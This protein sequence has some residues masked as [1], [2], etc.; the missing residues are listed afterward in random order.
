MKIVVL[1]I[2]FLLNCLGL[3]ASI[4]IVAIT[5]A[6][7]TCNGS[8]SVEASGTAGSFSLRI[9]NSAGFSLNQAMNGSI[10]TVNGLCAG[11]YTIEVINHFGCA[12]VMSAQVGSLS[13]NSSEVSGDIQVNKRLNLSVLKAKAFPNPFKTDFQ[14]ELDWDGQPQEMINL[15]VLNAL[16]QV[17]HSQKQAAAKGRNLFDIK[18]P[19]PSS[20][21]MLQVLIR[22]QHGRQVVLKLIQV[23]RGEELKQD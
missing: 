10:E 4:R 21:G 3:C 17:L 6:N 19:D 13:L 1:T 8:I 20:R 5:S 9:S 23:S 12:K 15:E 11:A 18:L 22:D 2:A 14:V 7:A 16:G